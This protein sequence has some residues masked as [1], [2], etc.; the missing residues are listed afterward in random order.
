MSLFHKQIVVIGSSKATK[1]EE[2]LAYEVGCEI[3][4]VGYILVCGGREGVMEQACRG[5]KQNGGLTVGILPEE[6]LNSANNY[7]DIVIPT[8]IGFA[9]NYIVQNS[10]SVI[11]MV[12]GSF[13]TLS[14]LAYALQ[15]GKKVIA[16]GSKWRK[17]DEKIIIAKDPKDAVS[18]AILT[19]QH[20][21]QP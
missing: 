2:K 1:E 16:V 18:K 5:A 12:G 10:G 15:F 4:K 9:R 19:N 7:L 8:G 11:I 3:G 13:G 17:I 14:E 20:L 6:N 21:L